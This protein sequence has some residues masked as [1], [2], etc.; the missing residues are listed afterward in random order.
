M[1]CSVNNQLGI[2]SSEFSISDL[3]SFGKDEWSIPVS[4]S[5]EL[6][7]RRWKDSSVELVQ[8]EYFGR[9]IEYFAGV[10]QSESIRG[11]SDGVFRAEWLLEWIRSM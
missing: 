4:S 2:W 6:G 8:S 5:A 9:N 1:P 10:L 7:L 3:S 11:I